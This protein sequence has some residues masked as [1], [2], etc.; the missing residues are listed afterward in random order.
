LIKHEFDYEQEYE[1]VS[2]AGFLPVS[3]GEYS[4]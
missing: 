3:Q 4:N 1:T 2:T